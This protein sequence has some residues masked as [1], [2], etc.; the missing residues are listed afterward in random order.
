[1]NLGSCIALMALVAACTPQQE[2]DHS[3]TLHPA[4]AAPVGI[5]P[6]LGHTLLLPG[7]GEFAVDPTALP[8][9]RNGVTLTALSVKGPFDD[10]TKRVVHIPKGCDPNFYDVEF[11]V[12]NGGPDTIVLF[13]LL[14]DSMV[15]ACDWTAFVDGRWTGSFCY[16]DEVGEPQTLLPPLSGHCNVVEIEVPPDSTFH[17]TIP[18]ER[19]R[20]PIKVALRVT[21]EYA[22]KTSQRPRWSTELASNALSRQPR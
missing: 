20:S 15:H 21:A 18:L 8:P 9:D 6:A 13:S 16:V 17:F 11:A 5:D 12:H 14:D 1:M 22:V 2:P 3:A 10:V 4:L 7:N 19:W